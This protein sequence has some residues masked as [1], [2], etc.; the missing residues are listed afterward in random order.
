[1][2]YDWI[3]SRTYIM[4]MLQS[5]WFYDVYITLKWKDRH[6]R[7][8]WGMKLKINKTIHS[9][10]HVWWKFNPRS[11]EDV[12]NNKITITSHFWK[13]FLLSSACHSYFKHSST[14][15]YSDCI[16]HLSSYLLFPI[17]HF[18]SVFLPFYSML[19]SRAVHFFMPAKWL[20]FLENH[21]LYAL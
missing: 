15:V 1:M 17:S 2:S 12:K 13:T 14:C 5:I 21:N 10:I 3:M 8:R 16:S 9:Y 20:L 19:C 4:C 7:W 18:P 6:C 11:K